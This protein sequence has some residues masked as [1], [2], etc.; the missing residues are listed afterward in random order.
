MQARSVESE[1]SKTHP[2]LQTAVRLVEAVSSPEDLFEALE[3]SYRP[4]PKTR[5]TKTTKRIYIE[6]L[7]EW[8]KFVHQNTKSSNSFFKKWF[9]KI[10]NDP[11][12]DREID[13]PK[14]QDILDAL[15]SSEDILPFPS[16]ALDNFLSTLLKNQEVIT[17]QDTGLYVRQRRIKVAY[18][19]LTWKENSAHSVWA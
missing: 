14:V 13:F 16:H 2:S 18:R 3:L 9:S 12:I 15:N 8:T 11:T 4:W 19:Y 10:A 17:F 5:A 1:I 6:E 7:L